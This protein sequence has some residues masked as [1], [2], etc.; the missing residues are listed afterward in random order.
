M[1]GK[2]SAIG[3]TDHILGYRETSVIL[4]LNIIPY[5]AYFCLVQ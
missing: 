1:V 5:G 3:V 4:I 2:E